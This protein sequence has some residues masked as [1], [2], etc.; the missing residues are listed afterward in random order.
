MPSFPADAVSGAATGTSLSPGWGSV[1][2]GALGAV[3]GLLGGGGDTGPSSQ[4]RE[5]AAR[6]SQYTDEQYLYGGMA[7]QLAA[8]LG[9]EEARR[10]I[11]GSLSQ[12]AYGRLFGRAS[13][14]ADMAKV[15]QELADLNAKLAPYRAERGNKVDDRAAAAAGIDPKALLSRIRELET[16]KLTGVDPGMKG[17][18]DSAAFD[19]MGPGMMQAYQQM[20]GDARTQ[21]AATLG[22]FGAQTN[23]LMRQGR[24]VEQGAMDFGKSEAA[25]INRDADRALTGLNRQTQAQMMGRGFGAST[26]LTQALAGNTRSI[27]ESKNDALGQLGDAQIRLLTGIR[28]NNLSML[29]NRMGVGT[30]LD[31]S[32]QD[33]VMG[34]QQNAAGLKTNLLTGGVT[35]PFLSRSTGAYVPGLSQGQPS[36]T[37][38]WGNL[39][40]G[41]GGQMFGYGIRGLMSP[42]QQGNN[43]TGTG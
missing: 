8:M 30:Q 1:I 32:N 39:L 11:Q 24:G 16:M 40:S 22:R 41:M 20:I 12:D 25:R 13:G 43:A 26:A 27:Q 14:P 23:E 19:Q 10:I 37:A 34:M 3:G 5:A 33:R 4:E 21:G 29:G 7:R 9:P 2:G 31:L 15:D 36:Q 28:G 38:Q 18:I 6:A 42:N 17:T 35:N